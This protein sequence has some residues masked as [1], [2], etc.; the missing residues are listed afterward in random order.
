MSIFAFRKSSALIDQLRTENAWLRSHLGRLAEIPTDNVRA[1][2]LGR[3]VERSLRPHPLGS[4]VFTSKRTRT[5]STPTW[6]ASTIAS[7]SS[8]T[9]NSARRSLVA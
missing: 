4:H 6:P 7:R 3:E 1:F 8:A 2:E 5:T 9:G